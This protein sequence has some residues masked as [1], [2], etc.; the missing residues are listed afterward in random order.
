MSVKKLDQ[1]T[2]NSW[3]DGLTAKHSIVGVQAKGERFVFAPLA[4]AA[5]LRLDYDVTMLPP[6]KYLLPQTE[7]LLT[8]NKTNGEHKSVLDSQPLVLFG[9]HPYD[10]IAINQMDAIFSK[11]NYDVHYMTRRNNA[12]IVACDVQKASANVFAGCME[13][14]V[15]KEGFDVLLT[16]VN[17]GYLAETRTEKGEALFAGVDAP[18][19]SDKDLAGREQVWKDNKKNLQKHKL[20][21]FPTDI[22]SLLEKSFNHK[23]WEEKAGLCFSCGT[24]TNVCPT[25]YCFDVQDDVN[26]DMQSGERSRTWDSCQLSEFAIVAGKHNFRPDKGA[27]FRH[28][29]YRKGKYIA[30][31]IGH[32]ACVGCGRCITG[33]VA[34]IANPVEIYNRLLEGE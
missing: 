10:M 20:K 26:W 17:G 32:I 5:D 1:D 15:V 29:Y 6:K 16:R 8:F 19:A 7:P 30:D 2:F 25:C 28:R 13:T 12:T 27:R 22:P 33:C 18:D 14:A 4:G 23:V 24:C 21:C 3:V 31:K 11:D 9:V 34:A